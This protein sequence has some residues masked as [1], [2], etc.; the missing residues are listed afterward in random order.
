MPGFAC[1]L[2]VQRVPDSIVVADADL[3]GRCALE[4]T[5]QC[6]TSGDWAFFRN[7][8]YFVQRAHET[9]VMVRTR[10]CLVFGCRFPSTHVTGS[11]KC[12]A[13]GM[14]GHGRRECGNNLRISEL[15]TRERRAVRDRPPVFPSATPFPNASSSPDQSEDPAPPTGAATRVARPENEVS[16]RCPICRGD[17]TATRDDKVFT[18]SECCVCYESVP[19]VVCRPCRHAV[20]CFSCAAETHRG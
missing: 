3:C 7:N 20:V 6:Q 5:D 19:L 12:G 9:H 13:C 8:F 1:R 2:C 10:T 16:F 17:A 11:H 15:A 4:I 14:V 18:G